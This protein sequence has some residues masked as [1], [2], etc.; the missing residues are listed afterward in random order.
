[1]LIDSEDR[2]KYLIN[3]DPDS[4]FYDP[5][6]RSMRD[7]PNEG[8]DDSSVTFTGDNASKQTGEMG[9]F[10]D[11]QKYAWEEYGAVCD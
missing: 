7:N 4:A 3:L 6:S 8:K 1:L 9:E 2:A 11:L 10:Y 5:K